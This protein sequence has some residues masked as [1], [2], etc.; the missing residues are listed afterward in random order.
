MAEDDRSGEGLKKIEPM[1]PDIGVGKANEES[2]GVNENVFRM[3]AEKSIAGIYVV[4]D[5][6]F[7]F[8][9]PNAASYAGY[10]PS[11]IV[12]TQASSLIHPDDRES[13]R[14]R[15]RAVLQGSDAIQNEFRIVTKQGDVRWILE[16]VSPIIYEGR[17]AILG[18]AMDITDLK[19]AEEALRESERR[20]RRMFE[21]APLGIFQST[22]GGKII[23]VNHAYARMF[24]YDSVDD[25]MASVRDVA[26]DLYA[27]PSRRLNVMKLILGSGGPVQV[28][29]LYRRKD[30]G[31]FTG[32]LHAWVLREE[33][34]VIKCLEGFVEDISARK[35]S[36][37]VLKTQAEFLQTLIDAIPIPVFFKDTEG[38][39]LGCNKACEI[40]FGSRERVIG[41]TVYGIAPR[42][43]ADIYYRADRELFDNPGIQIYE[44]IAADRQG[45]RHNVIFSKAT[46]LDGNGNVAGLIGVI[47][48]ITEQK[49]A[50]EALKQSEEQYRLLFDNMMS[51]FALHEIVCDPE[52]RPVDYRFVNVNKAFEMLTGLPG[53][54]IIGRNVTEVLPGIEP[55]WI[56]RYG[57]VAL[58]GEQIHFEDYSVSLGKHFD[59][60]AFSPEQGKFAV[61]FRDISERR[62]IEEALRKSEEQYRHIF[63]NVLEGMFQSTPE[64]RYRT[65]NPALARMF[66]YHSPEEMIEQVT[67]IGRQLYADSGERDRCIRILEESG[68]LKRFEVQ[69]RRRDGS[70][71]WTVINSR[72]VR[73]GE[74]KVLLIEGIISDVTDLKRAEEALTESERR[75]RQ[76]Q[77]MEAIG[78]L[79]GGIAHDF[80]NILAAIIG[81]TEM[82]QCSN[83]TKKQILANLEYILK[84]GLRAKDLVK[85]I[86]AFSRQSDQELKPISIAP[87]LKEA[88]KMLRASLPSTIHIRH[89]IRAG[90]GTIL[91]D[92]TQIHQI[93]MNIATNAAHAMNEKGGTLGIELAEVTL[94]ARGAAAIHSDLGSGPYLRLTISDT[95]QGI[96]PAILHRI[97][98]PFFTTKDPGEGTGMGLAMVHGIVKSYGGIVTVESEPGKG[99]AFD[100]YFPM[101]ESEATK[102]EVDV[103][104]LAVGK[105][106]VL[107]V[108]DEE[109]LTL[110]G[111]K[112]LA[113]LG[114]E[115]VTY[116][117]SL[118][119]LEAFRAGP[120]RFDL[121]ITDQT[122]PQ[123]T[124]MEL[125]Q[126]ILKIRP[127]IPIIMCTGFSEGLTP[128]KAKSLGIREYLMKPLVMRQI[129]D[130]VSKVMENQGEL[131][132]RYGTRTDH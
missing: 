85:Q 109:A 30:G 18:N 57:R 62:Q 84:A 128:E 98:D 118:E 127:D 32:M 4:Q 50:D 37:N 38:I 24:G 68:T 13:A 113:K 41:K 76:A 119:A 126:E 74:G 75:L 40:F 3:L 96:N 92:P 17:Q 49:R 20:Y 103:S 66:G 91:A 11:E 19:R 63:E 53:A 132:L 125:A 104:K 27:D 131:A 116:T 114:Y 35:A 10:E 48:D 122:M 72:I 60:L 86:L 78:T 5:G 36:E 1:G 46:Y 87:L 95:G 65:V 88:V 12:G 8:V 31:V 99:T 124:G 130:T 22:P 97:F 33:D 102:A 26:S 81:Y 70:I 71:L 2:Q 51:G 25:L 77:K 34:G 16:T 61:L 73:D 80:N 108:D 55:S 107:F 112:I 101:M 7:R 9:N 129:A 100:I 93:V 28:E 39:Y 90:T 82:S 89:N 94:D 110:L 67:D 45:E 123:M 23:T 79:A 83:V 121:V 58:Q 15:S 117:G 29:N 111:G 120:E 64:G 14:Q 69:M 105:G 6:V 47:Y 106:R 56:E 43:I 44:T 115:V 59:V 42:E 52:G 54:D 21:D